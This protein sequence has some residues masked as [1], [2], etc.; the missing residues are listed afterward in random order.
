VLTIAI[1][2]RLKVPSLEADDRFR[3]V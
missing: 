3:S 1:V 2:N